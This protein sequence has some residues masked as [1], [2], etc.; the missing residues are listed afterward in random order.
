V[1][2]RACGGEILYAGVVWAGESDF[3]FELSNVA[4]RAY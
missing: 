4:S 1:A 3:H 2:S